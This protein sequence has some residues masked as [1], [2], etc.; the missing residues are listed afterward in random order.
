TWQRIR[1]FN[2]AVPLLK[3]RFLRE[4]EF[5]KIHMMSAGKGIVYF[6][7][8]RGGF[9]EKYLLEVQSI[10]KPFLSFIRYRYHF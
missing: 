4:T 1:N 3:T 8:C 5:F 9:Y 10:N 6:D 7:G 2:R